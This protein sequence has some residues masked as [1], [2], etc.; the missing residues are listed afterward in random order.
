MFLKTSFLQFAAK[1][2]RIAFRAPIFS[3]SFSEKKSL[4]DK[5]HESK[6]KRNVSNDNFPLSFLQNTSSLKTKTPIE[7][8]ARDLI[9]Q[10]VNLAQF[11]FKCYQITGFS[12]GSFFA[13]SFILSTTPLAFASPLTLILGGAIGSIGGIFGVY[14]TPQGIKKNE[15]QNGKFADLNYDPLLRKLFYG[16]FIASSTIMTLPFMMKLMILSPAII[17]A[18]ALISSLVMAGSSIYALSKPQG[19]FKSWEAGLYGGLLALIGM[20]LTSLLATMMIGPNIFS[21]ICYRLDTYIGLG[22]FT[23][24]QIYDTQRA[25]DEYQNGNID[26]LT[27]SMQF[28]LNFL[29]IF[30]RIASIISDI[31]SSL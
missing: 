26:Y 2:N 25:I 30:R 1:Q 15:L 18:S 8:L 11:L 22:L 27:N 21:M 31:Y 5:L 3:Y 16:T 6:L 29:G 13:G 12:I 23:A 14:M 10:D 17:P 4:Q 9:K 7:P 20:N 19:A 28:Y 24:Y